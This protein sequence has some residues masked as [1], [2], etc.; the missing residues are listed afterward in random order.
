MKEMNG[1]K[2]NQLVDNSNASISEEELIRLAS[3]GLS[4]AGSGVKSRQVD[5]AHTPNQVLTS[6]DINK[7]QY[8]HP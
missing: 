6:T 2:V 1:P 3:D 7:P 5:R 8:M 4:G